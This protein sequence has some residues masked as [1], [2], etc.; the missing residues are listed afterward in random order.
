MLNYT[1]INGTAILNQSHHYLIQKLLTK[2]T[3][4]QQTHEAS[5][6]YCISDISFCAANFTDKIMFTLHS[7]FSSYFMK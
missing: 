5:L 4:G 6:I 3:T 7:E 1:R 2:T